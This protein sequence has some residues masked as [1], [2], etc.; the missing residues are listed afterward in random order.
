MSDTPTLP[1][2]VYKDPTLIKDFPPLVDPIPP[3]PHVPNEVPAE[4]PKTPTQPAS[5][6]KKQD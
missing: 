1:R 5:P 2:P 4:Q 6:P 3:M